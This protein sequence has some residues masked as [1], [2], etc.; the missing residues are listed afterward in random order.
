MGSVGGWGEGTRHSDVTAVE[1][2][3]YS[4]ACSP[5]PPTANE[6]VFSL[7]DANCTDEEK[8]KADINHMGSDGLRFGSSFQ[9]EE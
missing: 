8:G 4:I 9:A 2:G 5:N 7:R 6:I 1:L 3:W